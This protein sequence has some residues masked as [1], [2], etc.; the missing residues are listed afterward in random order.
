M[1]PDTDWFPWEN[2]VEEDRGYGTVCWQWVG[3]TPPTASTVGVV[4]KV[5][6][7]FNEFVGGRGK[8]KLWM[9]LCERYGETNLCVRP[10]HVVIGTK[11]ANTAHW[12]MLRREAGVLN[13]GTEANRGSKRSD[14]TRQL[15]A[16]SARRVKE[17][18]V[19]KG[20]YPCGGCGRSFRYPAGKTQHKCGAL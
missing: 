19:A 9:H 8:G 3:P 17:D 2:V 5:K 14:E 12:H 7:L 1:I 10:D 20:P 15:M 16:D 4:K 11:A 13:P 18:Q 6:R